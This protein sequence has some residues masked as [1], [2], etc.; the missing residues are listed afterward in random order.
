MVRIDG[1]PMT[2]RPEVDRAR[3]RA[4][5]IGML[6]QTANLFEHLTVAENVMVAQRLAGRTD[7]HRVAELFKSLALGSRTR[8]HPSQLSGG[9]TARA[10]LAVALANQPA[11]VLADE[12]TGELDTANADRVVD[13]LTRCARDGAAVVVVTHNDAVAA[14]ADRRVALFDGRIAP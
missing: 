13:L 10:G 9:E 7:R 11:V 5:R 2:R 4:G 3:L 6:F 8:A 12:P 1:H 14:R